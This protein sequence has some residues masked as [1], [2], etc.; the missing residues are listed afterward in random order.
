VSGDNERIYSGDASGKVVVT[1]T[2]SL[3]AI[4]Q[5]NAHTDSILGVEEWD[6]QIVTHA[7]DNKLHVWQRIKDIP[8]SARLGGSAALPSLPVPS[9]CYSIDVN[10][11]N[12][13]RFSLL[14]LAF[15]SEKESK[16]LIALP[17][18]VDS[19]TVDIWS[20]PTLD[21]IHAAIGQEIQKSVFSANPGGRNTSGIIM[22][23]HLYHQ[24]Q[25]RASTSA[26][27]DKSLCLLCAY[28]DGSVV[29]REYDQKNKETSV[30]GVGWNIVW[31]SKL[32]VESIMAMRVSRSNDFALT[33]SAD[34]LICR[35]DLLIENPS[36]EKDF[37][38]FRTNH[39]GNGSIVIRDD[40][41]VTAVG[42]WDG[43]IR[44]YSTKSFKRLGTLK[45]HKFACQCLEFARSIRV[46]EIDSDDEE[47]SNEEKLNRSRWLFAGG[48]DN[49]VSIWPL[50]SFDKQIS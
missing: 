21:R 12:F 27:Q 1:S 16:A 10:A 13:C 11:L 42:G 7:R 19:S 30:E 26:A 4:T 41:K 22:S 35:Y 46:E 29:L 18:L 24:S 3:R 38:A 15:E 5:W 50:I 40:G 48:K 36:P 9:I 47:L 34:N 20:L 31:K 44:L 6:D 49:R 23:L 8:F 17:N 39:A 28:E 43:K 45:Y 14:K 33:I 37:I 2:G 32:H 25:S